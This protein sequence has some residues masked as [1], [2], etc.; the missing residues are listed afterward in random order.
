VT[1][2]SILDLLADGYMIAWQL[3]L[4]I[5]FCM[6]LGYR[7]ARRSE[8]NV[9]NWLVIGFL[10]A[11]PPIMGPLIMVIAWR[12]MP[13]STPRYPRAERRGGR[14]DGPRRPRRRRRPNVSPPTE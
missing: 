2:G 9:L 11:I 6:Y 8:R 12:W 5:P 13:P 1:V 7:T 3:G 14:R 10:A 4:Q